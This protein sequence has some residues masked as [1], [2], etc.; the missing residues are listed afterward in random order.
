MDPG[1]V[2]R[3]YSV[4]NEKWSEDIM[5]RF[6][7]LTVTLVTMWRINSKSIRMQARKTTKL[8]FQS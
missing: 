3:F 4:I 1:N 7:F 5:I 2:F 6:T 8:S